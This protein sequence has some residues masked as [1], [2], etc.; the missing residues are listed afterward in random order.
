M[1]ISKLK[2]SFLTSTSSILSF[3]FTPKNLLYSK[4]PHTLLL[5]SPKTLFWNV[6]FSILGSLAHLDIRH[7]GRIRTSTYERQFLCVEYPC[8]IYRLGRRRFLQHKCW[9]TAHY[10]HYICL[11]LQCRLKK[12]FVLWSRWKK[13]KTSEH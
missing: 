10:F 3:L 13:D 7:S 1:G 2:S 9:D 12:S 6:I 5:S 11:S 8:I 4:L